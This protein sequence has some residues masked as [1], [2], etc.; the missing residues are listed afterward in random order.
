VV[1]LKVAACARAGC[2]RA[3]ARASGGEEVFQR[4]AAPS[5]LC[6]QQQAGLSSSSNKMVGGAQ[7]GEGDGVSGWLMQAGM[8]E[9]RGEVGGAALCGRSYI[10]A[11][12]NL[13]ASCFKHADK[14]YECHAQALAASSSRVWQ[15]PCTQRWCTEQAKGKSARERRRNAPHCLSK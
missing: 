14:A 9:V 4:R 6:A 2:V 15:H 3:A 13:G 8:W 7:G 5:P 12:P 10:A 11:S 1:R